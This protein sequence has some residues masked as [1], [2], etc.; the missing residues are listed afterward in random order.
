MTG[1]YCILS[2]PIIKR[3]RLSSFPGQN[4]DGNAFCP[5]EEDYLP[6]RCPIQGM[7]HFELICKNVS[8]EQVQTNFKRNS[9]TDWDHISLE[10][11]S[12]DIFI[13]KNVFDNHRAIL[14]SLNGD[15]GN[16]E[17]VG[18]EIHPQALSSSRNVT[19]EIFIKSF[20]MRK[21]TFLFLSE[22]YVLE[23]LTIINSINLYL[24][25]LPPLFSL[26]YFHVVNCTAGQNGWIDF[27]SQL[28]NG[29]EE[30]IFSGCGLDDSSADYLLESILGSS[31][32]TLT[33]LNFS[34]NALT[35]IPPGLKY[36]TYITDIDFH[37]QREPGFGFLKSLAVSFS[38]PIETFDLR[39]CFITEIQSGIVQGKF[40]R[41]K[42]F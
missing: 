2:N 36:F 26:I 15:N 41:L 39:Y 12:K 1:G 33:R 42:I 32:E 14:L 16:S 9:N 23:K 35:R 20:D 11:W 24:A 34:H 38:A 37:G 8:L 17:P 25:S 21:L 19:V 40:Y 27:P 13:P 5:N 4:I 10:L 29:L 31:N 30:I 3:E 28:N 7:K 6:C 18:L 22:F